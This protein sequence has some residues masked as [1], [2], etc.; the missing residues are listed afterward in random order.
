MSRRKK[1]RTKNTQRIQ[2]RKIVCTK[3]YMDEK[4]SG[5]KNMQAKNSWRKN[6]QRKKRVTKK[7]GTK[8]CDMKISRRKNVRHKIVI[9]KSSWLDRVRRS[10]VRKT[11]IYAYILYTIWSRCVGSRIPTARFSG[12]YQDMAP[13]YKYNGDVVPSE[14]DWSLKPYF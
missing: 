2:E 7:C 9:R 3:K 14:T 5:R 13:Q 1:T 12:I 10:L 6:T 4:M 11:S 8:N